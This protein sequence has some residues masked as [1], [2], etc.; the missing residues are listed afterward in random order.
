MAW[1]KEM[2]E[3]KQCNTRFLFFIDS[4]NNLHFVLDSEFCLQKMCQY[5]FAV[6]SDVQLSNPSIIIALMET[7]R[8]S[9]QPQ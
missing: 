9:L 7:N 6:D 8:H 4:T 2:R 3:I 5:L 1:M